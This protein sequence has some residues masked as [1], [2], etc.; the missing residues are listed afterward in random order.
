MPRAAARGMIGSP[1]SELWECGTDVVRIQRPGIVA[2][3]M[4]DCA[5]QF[6]G[7]PFLGFRPRYTNAILAKRGQT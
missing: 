2:T 5:Y 7:F 6:L 3:S 1:Q 4:I